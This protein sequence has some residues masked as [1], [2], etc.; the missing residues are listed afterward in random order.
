MRDRSRPLDEAV[1]ADRPV[2]PLRDVGRRI[3]GGIALVREVQAAEQDLLRRVIVLAQQRQRRLHDAELLV[4]DDHA[5][6]LALDDRGRVRARLRE[7][8]AKAGRRH[9]ERKAGGTCELP[10]FPPR[11]RGHE[12][13]VRHLFLPIQAGSTTHRCGP[14]DKRRTGG[15]I[16]SLGLEKSRLAAGALALVLREADLVA[17]VER[18]AGARRPFHLAADEIEPAAVHSL[19]E[20]QVAQAARLPA[21][22][23]GAPAA[24]S[25]G[26]RASSRS[27]KTNMLRW[28]PCVPL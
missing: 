17:R 20:K 9:A 11:D 8:R 1:D 14:T 22:G 5:G 7:C 27:W 3:P 16:Y 13:R 19:R 25:T 28:Q 18:A 24:I 10:E 26:L 21:V 23:E 6:H 4:V 12:L 15:A 2:L